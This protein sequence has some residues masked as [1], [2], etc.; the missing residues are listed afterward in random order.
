MSDDRLRDLE[1]RW[2]ET[3]HADDHGRY[4]LARVRSG[5]LDE[6]RL[7][8]AAYCGHA[9]ALAAHPATWSFADSQ[10][11]FLGLHRFGKT[12]WV[13]AMVLTCDA[14]DAARLTFDRRPT[15]EEA[16]A[17][18]ALRRAILAGEDAERVALEL[19]DA[20]FSPWV[21]GALLM[22]AYD[23]YDDGLDP[24]TRRP[25]WEEVPFTLGNAV[26]QFDEVSE[27]IAGEVRRRLAEWALAGPSGS[28]A[29]R[30]LEDVGS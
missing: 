2:L 17:Y 23:A 6:R 1:R 26:L 19:R 29:E 8:L 13:V 22:E 9:G 24:I 4:L 10:E 14:I 5:L 3:R 27:P 28:T 7:E 11:W 12:V 20:M 16:R 15:P 21:P 30:G 18:G 25:A